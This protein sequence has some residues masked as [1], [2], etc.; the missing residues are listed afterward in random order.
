MATSDDRYNNGTGLNF[1][2]NLA[3][4]YNIPS[5]SKILRMSNISVELMSV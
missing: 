1:V 2:N 3:F 4:D 5:L